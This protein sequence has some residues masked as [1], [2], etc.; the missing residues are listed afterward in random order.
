MVFKE[1][2]TES[3]VSFVGLLV[4]CDV[5]I[6]KIEICHISSDSAIFKFYIHVFGISILKDS[7]RTT[8]I[9]H[10]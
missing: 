4:F 5:S 7:C 2:A 8:A 6:S 10:F 9:H 1:K 3:L